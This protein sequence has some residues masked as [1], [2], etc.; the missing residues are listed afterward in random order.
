MA[1]LAP[2]AVEREMVRSRPLVAPWRVRLSGGL[3]PYLFVLPKYLIFAVFMLYP[4]VRAVILTF[5]SGAI[6]QG[7][8]FVGFRNYEKI[9]HDEIFWRSLRNSAYYTVL[10]IP[11]VIAIGIGL[12]TLLNRPIRFRPLFIALLIVPS[13]AST[14]AASVIWSYLLRTDGGVFNQIL[15][16]FGVEPVNWLGTPS[17]VMPIVVALEVWRGMGFY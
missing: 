1:N 14:V 5:Q 15:G 10:V 13:V 12:A 8:D 3:G 17:L 9:I 7:L 6:L 4:L 16:A 2:V 11:T